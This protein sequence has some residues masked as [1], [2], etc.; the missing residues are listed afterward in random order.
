MIIHNT[1]VDVKYNLREKSLGA[2]PPDR[3]TRNGLGPARLGGAWAASASPV[4]SQTDTVHKRAGSATCGGFAGRGRG[5]TSP[6]RGLP[7]RSRRG[8]ERDGEQGDVVALGPTDA[9]P[10]GLAA[11]VGSR[12]EA[13]APLQAGAAKG[14]Q[15]SPD[16]SVPESTPAPGGGD[17]QVIEIAAAR[18]V[19]A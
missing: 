9:T 4:S 6:G 17:G 5:D 13:E 8:P 19:A 3:E 2:E 10:E 16:K 14:L 7:F 11:G 18:V 12:D 1:S 15:A